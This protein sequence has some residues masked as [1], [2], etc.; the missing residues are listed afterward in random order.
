M[1]PFQGRRAV[2]RLSFRN[3]SPVSELQKAHGSFTVSTGANRTHQIAK[4]FSLAYK[5]NPSSPIANMASPYRLS[6]SGGDRHARVR[7]P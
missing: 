2:F 7:G 3:S 6:P 4:V 5:I 1:A